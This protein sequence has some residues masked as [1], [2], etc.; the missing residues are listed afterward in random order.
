LWE[1]GEPTLAELSERYGVSTR[2]LQVHFEKHGTVKGSK[3]REI[4][5]AIKEQVFGEML[6]D[7][8]LKLK[9]AKETREAAYR[10]AVVV[11]NLVMA[12][13]QE[14]QKDPATAY[15]A[16]AAI[17][18]LS[19]AAATLER[20]HTLKWSALGLDR[21]SALSD[22]LPVLILQDL[23][24]KEIEQMRASQTEDDVALDLGV[25][26]EKAEQ[27]DDIVSEDGDKRVRRPSP[28]PT[29]VATD[30]EGFRLVRGASPG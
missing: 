20:T 26:S 29:P 1:T 3:A 14:A 22:E 5:A 13:L 4:A 23:T 11:E 10:N 19:L 12:Q 8:D 17:K 18:S 24:K 27:P 30:S 15:R 21:D 7:P 28:L 2:T 6:D 25:D 9:R 16:A